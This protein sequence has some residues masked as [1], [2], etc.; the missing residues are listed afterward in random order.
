MGDEIDEP[1]QLLRMDLDIPAAWTTAD[2]AAGR[3]MAAQNAVIMSSRI[4]STQSREK[5]PWRPVTPSAVSVA[6]APATSVASTVRCAV[7]DIKS[8]ISGCQALSAQ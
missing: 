1:L 3:W 8:S 4:R 2:G 6:T 5:A 7:A